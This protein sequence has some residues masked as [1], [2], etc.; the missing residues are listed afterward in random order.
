[1]RTFFI[2]LSILISTH[3]Y[4]QNIE[5]CYLREII[6][7]LKTLETNNNP[8]AIGD[9]GRAY[10]VLQIHKICVKD[11]NRAYGTKFSHKDAFIPYKAENIA[12][13]YL[14]LGVKVFKRKYNR[15]PTDEELIRMYNGGIYSGYKKRATRTYYNRY[16]RLVNN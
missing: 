6:D 3:N 14:K 16:I 12:L 11:V 15:L 13:L 5:D 8:S 2:I 7:T 4:S 1:M 10:G 9:N